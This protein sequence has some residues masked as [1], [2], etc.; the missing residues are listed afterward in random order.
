MTIIYTSQS[1]SGYN[2]GPPPDDGSTGSDNEI[3]WLK[4]KTKLADPIKTLAEALN[5]ELVTAF[6]KIFLNGI[7]SKTTT[8]TVQTS[9]RGKLISCSGTF[10]V[11]LLAAASATN[12]FMAALINNG[13]GVIT[14]DGDTSETINGSTTI[15][16]NPGEW[17]VFTTDGSTWEGLTGKPSAATAVYPG[18]VELA[19]D[20]ETLTGTD[21]S[22]A[23]TPANVQAKITDTLGHGALVYLD[24]NQT[25]TTS[26]TTNIA[27]DQEDYDTDTIHYNA[28]NNTRLTVPTGVTKVR[29]TAHVTWATG[30]TGYRAITI[31][32]GG[33]AAYSG[34][35]QVL[36]DAS[37]SQPGQQVSTPVLTVVAGNYFD[38]QVFH[39]EGTNLDVVGDVNGASTW[40]AME[41][42]K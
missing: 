26:T 8:Y 34:H 1:I 7:T 22:R 42:I 25:I 30:T 6:G 14:L 41:I 17:I 19:T 16:L 21:T 32:K 39:T 2:S 37:A 15:T 33:L 20:A 28:T 36:D 9:D 4:H 38:L 13:S 23:T 11:S 40:F 31:L 27:F 24:A 5:S 29:L 35:P 12:G 10:T 3:T 18:I